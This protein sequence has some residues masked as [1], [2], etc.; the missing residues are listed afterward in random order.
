MPGK[1]PNLKRAGKR[2]CTRC[3]VVWNRPKGSMGMLCE[4]C[5]THCSRCDTE[6]VVGHKLQGRYKYECNAC[7]TERQ[8]QSEKDTG[9]NRRDYSLVYR[10]GITAVEYDAMLKRQDGACWICEKVPSKRQNRLAV[11]HLHVK[12]ERRHAG[13]NK[14]ARIR[15]L[16]CW[17]C[18]AAIGKFKDNVT[19]LRKAAEY[20]EV[21]PAQQYL[22][23]KPNE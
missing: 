5:T 6:L 18:N 11:D 2:K 22:K 15:G 3:K 16:L 10:F 8:L 13:R 1:R 17:S 19:H 23:E 9:W 4:R 20:L 21:W 14:R 7:K 12:G